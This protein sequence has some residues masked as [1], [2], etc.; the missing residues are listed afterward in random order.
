MSAGMD[1]DHIFFFDGKATAIP[2]LRE[3]VSGEDWIL[4][5]GS[6][7]MN[8]DELI[9]GIRE[10]VKDALSNTKAVKGD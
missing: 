3:N 6:R 2:A 5:K 4:L 10:F 8:L 7:R 9:P 1:K